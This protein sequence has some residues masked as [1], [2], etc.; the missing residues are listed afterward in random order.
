M[1]KHI[2]Q[3]QILRLTMFGDMSYNGYLRC[4]QKKINKENLNAGS[5]AGQNLHR[6]MYKDMSWPRNHVFETIKKC[7]LLFA[8]EKQKQTDIHQQMKTKG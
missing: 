7:P 2:F 4:C 5:S 6:V 8:F 1:F 3:Q